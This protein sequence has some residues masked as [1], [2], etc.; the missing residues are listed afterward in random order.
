MDQRVP[1]RL[2]LKTR[3]SI[4]ILLAVMALSCA[5]KAPSPETTE[6]ST[7]PSGSVRTPEQAVEIVRQYI[8]RNGGDPNREEISANW[9]RGN[10][11]VSAL[12]IWYSKN[13]GA[14]RFVP[15]GNTLYVISPNGHIIDAI[16]GK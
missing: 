8:R 4:L 3:H 13:Q 12:H 15:G 9:Y 16:P 6:V 2:R 1:T 11:S 10:W 14:S 5:H 7:R